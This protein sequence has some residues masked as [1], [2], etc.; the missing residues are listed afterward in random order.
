MML[1]AGHNPW[2]RQADRR[3]RVYVPSWAWISHTMTVTRLGGWPSQVTTVLE[4]Q[5]CTPKGSENPGSKHKA[6]GEI[7]K[8]WPQTRCPLFLC[9][10]AHVLLASTHGASSCLHHTP[11]GPRAPLDHKIKAERKGGGSE[12]QEEECGHPEGPRTLTA[13]G[14]PHLWLV[15]NS[16]GLK[17]KWQEISNI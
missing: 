7:E 12:T 9:P 17:T 14:L 4:N 11:Q 2:D 16:H 13:E 5:G 1:S 15:L 6:V 8:C 10:V 3:V